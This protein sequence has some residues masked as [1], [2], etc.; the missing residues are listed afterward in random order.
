MAAQA[1]YV[2]VQASLAN[3]IWRSVVILLIQCREPMDT[4]KGYR[5]IKGKCHPQRFGNL[6]GRAT[7]GYDYIIYFPLFYAADINS[8]VASYR[9]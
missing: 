1:I 2:K 5:F 6:R 9:V 8:R 4:W 7:G 3:G